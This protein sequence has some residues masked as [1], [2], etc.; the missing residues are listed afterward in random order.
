[1]MP[2]AVPS[3]SVSVYIPHAGGVWSKYQKLYTAGLVGVQR[4]VQN[5]SGLAS[6]LL[7]P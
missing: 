4:T 3:A 6:L 5:Y 1:M 2:H 7:F